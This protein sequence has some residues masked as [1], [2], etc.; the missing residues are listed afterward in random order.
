MG[1][2]R[3][4]AYNTA[5]DAA[6]STTVDPNSSSWTQSIQMSHQKFTSRS[7]HGNLVDKVF[8]NVIEIGPILYP[9]TNEI[10]GV[11]RLHCLKNHLP[12]Q[13]QAAAACLD[14]GYSLRFS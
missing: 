10:D 12:T 5:V 14:V 6:L 7:A 11:S 1:L 4:T 13:K 8:L 9:G 3:Y 2:T